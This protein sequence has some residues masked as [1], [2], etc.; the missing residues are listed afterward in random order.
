[1]RGAGLRLH[2]DVRRLWRCPACGAQRRLGA[3]VTSVSCQCTGRP[4]MQLIEQQRRERPFK[5]LT[6]TFLE[7][8]FAP[9][10]LNPPRSRE[11]SPQPTTRDDAPLG[12]SAERPTAR[13]EVDPGF[14]QQ[15]GELGPP[16]TDTSTEQR[17]LG[18]NESA[19][20]PGHRPR[21]RRVRGPRPEG[22]GH[23][24]YTPPSSEQKETQQ[25]RSEGEDFGEGIVS[26]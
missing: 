2:I 22:S 24:Q 13:N 14:D 6:S 15:R 16:A 25:P 10:E 7:F 11:E 17:P 26:Q 19:M 5:E 18:E 21:R 4:S 8:E 20:S 3:E 1:M 9:G 12:Q 23:N